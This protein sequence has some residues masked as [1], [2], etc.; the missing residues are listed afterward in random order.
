MSRNS[1]LPRYFAIE[2]GY[3]YKFYENKAYMPNQSTLIN[4]VSNF[5]ILTVI[6]RSKYFQN[7]KLINSIVRKYSDK[8]DKSATWTYSGYELLVEDTNNMLYAVPLI[9]V[10]GD[11]NS[12]LPYSSESY[13]SDEI[14]EYD[15]SH[16]S[17]YENVDLYDQDPYPVI[18][19]CPRSGGCRRVSQPQAY[20][21]QAAMPQAAMPQATMPQATVPQ[22]TVPQT[23][24]PQPASIPSLPIHVKNIIIADSISKNE[25]CPISSIDIDRTNASVTSCGHVFTTEAISRWL[26]T[27]IR[28][29]CPICKQKCSI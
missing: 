16:P 27:S 9:R 25:S 11:S 17:K 12:I 7:I 13:S 29:E 14:D 2:E 28:K 5:N 6:T 8:D 22:A 24:R 26:A 19:S 18:R 21:P 3:Q 23:T 4:I 10:M 1:S 20:E 15:V